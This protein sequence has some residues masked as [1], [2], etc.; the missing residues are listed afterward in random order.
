V[1]LPVLI[2]SLESLPEIRAVMRCASHFKVRVGICNGVLRNILLAD[3]NTL[4]ENPSL[5]D[6]VDPFGDIDLVFHDET[7]DG[8]FLQAG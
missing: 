2:K 3:P 5:F 6:F 1:D 8:V 4:V 7:A